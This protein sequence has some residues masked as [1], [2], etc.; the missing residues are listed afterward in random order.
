MGRQ[1]EQAAQDAACSVR[2]SCRMT[3]LMA[4]WNSAQLPGV[5]CKRAPKVD[6]F[7]AAPLGLVAAKPAI[8]VL[9]GR[10]PNCHFSAACGSVQR[11]FVGICGAARKKGANG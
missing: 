3:V 2:M 10:G 5:G 9:R 1:F 6:P 8:A 7:A 4:A 11:G